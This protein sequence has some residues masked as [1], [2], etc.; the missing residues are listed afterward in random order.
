MQSWLLPRLISLRAFIVLS[1]LGLIKRVCSSIQWL[2]VWPLQAA[3]SLS[4]AAPLVILISICI[5]CRS[6]LNT[7]AAALGWTNPTSLLSLANSSYV[8]YL[9]SMATLAHDKLA[10][11]A[12][13]VELAMPQSRSTHVMA[14]PKQYH[15]NPAKKASYAAEI[16]KQDSSS[17]GVEKLP[18]GTWLHAGYHL[19][20]GTTGPQIL[21]LPFAVAALGWGPGLFILCLGGVVSFYAYR[22]QISVI[23]RAAELSGQRSQRFRDLSVQALGEKWSTYLVAPLQFIV[24]FATVVSCIVLGGQTLK[25]IFDGQELSLY[26]FTIVFG[27]LHMLLSQLP[28][29]H[30]LRHLNL[31]SLLASISYC[32]LIVYGSISAGLSHDLPAKH[33]YSINGTLSQKIFGVFNAL[34][35]LSNVYGNVITVEIQSAIKPPASENM[36]KGLRLCYALIIVTI[37]P[38]AISGY[39]AFGNAANGNILKNIFPADSKQHAFLPN[40]ICILV[41]TFIFVQLVVSSLMYSHPTFAVLEEP[42]RDANKPM[43]AWQGLLLRLV[44]RCMFTVFATL[45]AAMLPYFGS[46]NALIGALGYT[47]LVFVVPIVFH[48]CVM[49]PKPRSLQRRL[50]YVMLVVF[51]IVA[52]LGFLA[53]IQQ[54][55]LDAKKYHLFANL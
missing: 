26:Q 54:L 38:V 10:A 12:M 44:S 27:C 25:A 13:D 11:T 4:S 33:D 42:I 1:A 18:E 5:T 45:L 47:P 55:V 3:A 2:K 35:I 21:S 34:S 52:T 31:L 46:I 40:W 17:K 9:S 23:D 39:W 51:S 41:N 6:L 50:N 28:S 36:M 49:R 29:L 53:S 30:S 8:N 15:S 22:L 32:I 43:S 16:G 20:S 7:S 48:L 24:C 19:T 14:P 37:L